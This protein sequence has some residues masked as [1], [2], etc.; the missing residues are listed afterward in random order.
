V[1]ALDRE[2]APRYAEAAELARGATTT[3]GEY[4][5]RMAGWNAVEEGLGAVR[6]LLLE[7]QTDM[8]SVPV[9]CILKT[10]SA[11]G[12]VLSS[13]GIELPPALSSIIGALGPLGGV[14]VED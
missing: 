10:F 3:L 13:F 8:D 1:V 12:S 6:S 4:E 7:A 9:A 5:A 14:C 11:L 2:L